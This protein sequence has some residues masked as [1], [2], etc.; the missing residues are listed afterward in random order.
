MNSKKDLLRSKIREMILTELSNTPYN[1]AYED[2]KG[3][4]LMVFG[5]TQLDNNAIADIVDD[6]DFYAEW[7]PREG[8]WFFPEEESLYDNLEDALGKEFSNRGIN[9][10]F[11]GIFN[12]SK[13]SEAE[14]EEDTNTEDTDVEDIK[15]ADTETSTGLDP[16]VKVVQDSLTQAQAAAQ[17]LGDKKLE[18]QIGNIITFFTRTHIVGKEEVS[19]YEVNPEKLDESFSRMKKIAGIIK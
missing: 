9:A 2:D 18:D 3:S 12:E 1:N 14:K 13:L 19:E 4:G 15:T 5:R 10:R 11:E 6:S 8:Y 16:N 17:L 7:N